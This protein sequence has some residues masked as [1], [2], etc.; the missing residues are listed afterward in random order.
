VKGLALIVAFLVLALPAPAGAQVL[1]LN[2]QYESSYEPMKAGSEAPA[3]GSFSAIVR[4]NEAPGVAR[5][6]TTTLGCFVY[7][8]GFDEQEVAGDCERVAAGTKIKATLTINR[9][10]GEFSHTTLIGQSYTIYTGHCA[11]AKKLF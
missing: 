11:A 5:I 3:T 8:G 9:I 1:T 10:N 4:M 6:E 7:V 2:C